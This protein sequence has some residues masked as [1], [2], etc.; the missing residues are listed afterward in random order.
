MMAV[1]TAKDSPSYI[2]IRIEPMPEIN[3]T[4]RELMQEVTALVR[5]RLGSTASVSG[6]ATLNPTARFGD[7]R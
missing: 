2:H 5:D 7:E 1:K 6:H 3:I 4:T